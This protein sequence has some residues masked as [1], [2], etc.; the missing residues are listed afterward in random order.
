MIVNPAAGRGKV[1]KLES[2][3]IRQVRNYFPDVTVHRTEAPGHATQIA[4]GL[5][6]NHVV[7]VVGGDGTIHETINGL[8]GGNS[9]LGVIPIGSGNDFIKVLHIPRD[10]EQALQVI[11]RRQ[12]M[13]MDVGK[14]GD[15]YFHNGLGI[16]FDAFVVIESN[17]VKWL[18][19]HLMYLFSIFKTLRHYHNMT[20]TLDMNGKSEQR[21]I[22]MITVGNGQSLGG[23][24]YLTPKAKI[25]DGLLDICIFQAL[26]TREI[27]MHLPKA[28]KGK[29]IFLP[30]VEYDHATKLSI[31]SPEG[32]PMHADGEL[33]PSDIHEI[34]I[35][36]VP[37]AIEVIHNL[38][39]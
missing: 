16:G 27:L 21:R 25:D 15:I 17:K 4:S 19:G 7:I 5:K 20:V 3:I 35:E 33:L 2:R 31:S 39:Q 37:R 30:Q 11:R 13:R 28:L 26:T 34:T 1:G 24:F 22:F 38:S 6:D 23:G 8:V 14:A 36:V 32:L 9:I 18:R 12:T 29:H 10:C